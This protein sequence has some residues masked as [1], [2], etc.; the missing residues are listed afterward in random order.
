VPAKST[1]TTTIAAML[2]HEDR[3]RRVGENEALYRLVN[4]RIQALSA[5]VITRTG[6][7]GVICECAALDCKTQIMISPT[8]YE[9]A[10]ANSDHFIVVRGH[11][12]NELE[13]LVEDHG[14]FIV[15]AK[16]PQEAKQIAEE[17]DPRT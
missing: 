6:E 4:E 17:M 3:L 14:S 1:I 8:V 11:E 7:F 2:D 10:R 15:I 5:G 9:Q 13:T 16:T 12:I